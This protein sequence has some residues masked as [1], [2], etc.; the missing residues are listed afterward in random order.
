ME[1]KNFDVR[2]HVKEVLL[3]QLQLL[4]EE[5]KRV[6][7]AEDFYELPRSLAMISEAMVNVASA[8]VTISDRQGTPC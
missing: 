4:Q 8:V 5:S 6:T 2:N 3:N 1:G 7:Q